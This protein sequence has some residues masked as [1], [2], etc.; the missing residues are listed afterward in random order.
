MYTVY[1]Y[2]C[3]CIRCEK[4]TGPTKHKS[5]NVW[6]VDN[7]SQYCY[8]VVPVVMYAKIDR[9]SLTFF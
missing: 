3:E 5:T 2:A 6:Y 1:R 7:L 9:L 4:S 8:L